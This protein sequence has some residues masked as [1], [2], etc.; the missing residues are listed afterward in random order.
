ML[1]RQPGV[2]NRGRLTSRFIFWVTAGVFKRTNL[3]VGG[4]G[5]QICVEPDTAV[6]W[7]AWER[8]EARK[9]L[10][11]CLKSPNITRLTVQTQ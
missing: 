2:D 10:R 9:R 7:Q 8:E 4:R 3:E 11:F 6:P 5:F 1:L